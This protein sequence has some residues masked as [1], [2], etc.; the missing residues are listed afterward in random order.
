MKIRL[1]ALLASIL[2]PL[3][4]QTYGEITGTVTDPTGAFIA[5]ASITVTNVAT[6][7]V[8][9]LETNPTGNYAVPFLVPGVYEVRAESAGLKAAVRRNVELQVE[10]VAR[11]DFK[12]AL[13]E[14]TQSVEVTGGAPL[15][16]TE[17]I[18]LGTVIENKRIVEL[19]L[20]GRNFLQLIA[21]SP[22]VTAEM[23]A[24]GYQ[25]SKQGGERANQAFSISGQR[26]Q[27]NHYTLDGVENTD[28]AFN[29]FIIRPSVEALQ[30]FKV[31]TGVFSAE[32]GRAPS[33]INATTKPGSNN[34][35][36]AVFEFLRN[37]KL[38]A[39]EWSNAGPKNPFRRNQF[40]FTLGGRLIRDKLFF[41][42]NFEALRDRK[43]LQRIASVATDRMRAGDFSTARAIYDPLSRV[44]GTD[45]AG[46]PRA[47]SA[48]RFPNDSI[49]RIRFHPIS[50]KLL[51]FYPQATVPGDSI[52]R[53]YI[54]NAGRPISWEQFMQRIDWNES[55][56]SSWF[57]RFSWGD[58][59]SGELGTFP[60]EA[61]RTTTKVYQTVLSNTRV[62][63]PAVV[64]EFRFGYNQFRN[65]FVPNFFANELDVTKGLGIVGLESPAAAVAWGT[66]SVSLAQGLTR[67]GDPD[68]GP[69]VIRTHVFQW[70]DNVS[71]VRGNHS[72]RFGGEIR[73]DRFNDAG[74]IYPRAQFTFEPRATFDPAR[75]SATGYAL[76]D[77]LLGEI[78]ISNRGLGRTNAM[79]RGTTVYLYVEDTWKIS[80]QLTMNVGLRYENTR[81]WHDK[82]RGIQNPQMFDPGVGPEGVLPTTRVPILTRP[83]KGDFHDGL[84]FRWNDAIPVQSGDQFLGRALVRP[85]N[86][87]F[88]PRLGLAYS[89][90]SNWTFRTGFGA[91]YSVDMNEPR[92]SPALN[93]AGNERVASN[94]ER[95][96]SNFSN[97]W[98]SARGSFRCSGWD[99]PCLGQPLVYANN[100]NRRTPYIFHWLFNLQRQ[101][102]ENVVW[103]AGYQGSSGHKLE[104]TRR[105]NKAINRSGPNDARTVEQRRP[106]PAYAVFQMTDGD[107][108]ANYHALSM[109]LQQRFSKGLTCL[110]GYTWSKSI[111]TGSAIGGL[112]GDP[113]VPKDSYDIASNRALSQF[114]TG[115]RLV[116]SF[117]YELPFG[118]GKPFA[119]RSGIL[120]NLI[121]GW[122]L[123]SIVTFSDGTPRNVGGIGDINGIG[124]DGNFPDATGVSP[125]PKNRR[126]QQFWNIAAFDSINPELTYR[127]G[128]I[129]RNILFGPGLRQW[130]FDLLRNIRVKEGHSLHVRFEAFNFSNH[131]NWTAPSTDPRS[132]N[133]GVITSARTMRELQFGLKYVF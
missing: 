41:L 57:G 12:L 118:M 32:F 10:A 102:S 130:D 48:T 75:R 79:L 20:N 111:D 65:D 24:G 46:N 96:N 104:G 126:A 103:E 84:P 83:G 95:P 36:G 52:L 5:G 31:Q 72:F 88:A 47:I 68:Q 78:F 123:G 8:R 119:N 82:Y 125:I 108:N 30:E 40:G 97:P 18:A 25:S 114:H 15:L 109:K 34:F 26:Q 1:I 100:V 6:N 112:S 21:L 93:L 81:P 16:A 99:G 127:Y 89:P 76:A 71:I 62:F 13:G 91:F 45:A 85:D 22:N 116:S 11:I 117:I 53:N 70:L 56:T 80:Q 54:R 61:G 74:F 131:P 69:Y 132:P 77:Y 4:A 73:R 94:E 92:V 86:N 9:Q 55:I 124:V 90:T 37:D 39:R 42:S 27:A 133:F 66:P 87:D 38:D 19:P 44:F 105:W 128:N 33:Q 3:S 110:V 59:Y 58:D 43:T 113:F 107:R 121:G 23:G 98:A 115:R 63:S 106:W 64:N 49:P 17:S 14:V 101:L 2:L 7:Q 122:Q 67:F 120:N 35:H 129:G 51:E 29:T 50:L 60:T 28:V